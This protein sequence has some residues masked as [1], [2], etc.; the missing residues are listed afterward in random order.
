MRQFVKENCT[1]PQVDQ[2]V[3]AN[4]GDGSVNL[5]KDVFD[6]LITN[7]IDK[8]MAEFSLNGQKYIAYS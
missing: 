4:D 8:E 7:L 5:T 3:D 2:Y 6:Q 1:L